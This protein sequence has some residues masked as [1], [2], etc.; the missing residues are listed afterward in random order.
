[1]SKDDIFANI[2]MMGMNNQDKNLVAPPPPVLEEKYFS[3]DGIDTEAIV[4]LTDK[5]STREELY[6]EVEKQKAYYKP[7]FEDY[8]PELKETRRKKDL[9][10][11]SWKV[12]TPEDAQDFIGLMQGKGE[13][14]KLNIP[15]FGEPRGVA[16]TYYRTTFD[17]TQE[18][19]ELGSIWVSFKGV[20][21]KAHVFMNGMFL[22][23]HEGFFAPFEFDFTA[24]AKVGENTLF[25]MVENDY[26]TM[27]NVSEYQGE[28]LTG[29]KLYAS[30][31]LGYDDPL[32][33]WHHCPPGMGIYQDVCIESRKDIFISDI[34][35]RPML[36][37]QKAEIWLELHS[38]Q[39]GHRDIKINLSMYGQNFKE[40][41]F[42][43]M[44]YKPETYLTVGTGDSL[45][46]ANMKAEGTLGSGIPM[47]MGRGVN[48]IKIPV[49]M[50]DIKKWELSQPW[51]YQL[52]VQIIDE[53]GQYGD[54]KQRHFGMRSFEMDDEDTPKGK[55]YF[56]GRQIRLRGAN[57]MGHEQQCVLKKDWEQLY[58]D[59]IL[60]KVCNMNFLRLTQ[61]PVQPEIYDF[62]DKIGLMIQTDL[63]LFAS[64]RRNQFVEAVRQ[65]QEME[66][67]IRSHPSTI[68]VSY[69]N[70][71][72]PNAQ[73]MPHRGLERAE[74]EDFFKCADLALKILNPD[75]VIKHV[76]GDYDP[77]TEGFPDNHCYPCWYN[78]HGIDIGKLHKGY[79]MAIKE[80]WHYGC[81]EYG[82]EGL[83][84]VSVMKKYY[85]TEWL[86]HTPK[87]EKNWSPQSILGA[88]TGNFHYF[89]YETQDTLES[90]VEES[91]KH[92]AQSTAL[93][94]QAFRRDSRMNSFAYHLF[95]DAFPAGWMK[96]IMDVDRNPKQAYF[97]YRDALTPVMVSLRTDRVKVFEKECINVEA[98]I[99][100][101]THKEFK[102]ATINY[103]VMK[104]G[105]VFV[106]QKQK[107]EMPVC[108]SK[109]QGY[110]PFVAPEVEERSVYEIHLS[111]VDKEE[112]IHQT[113]ISM[114]VFPAV[115]SLERKVCFIGKKTKNDKQLREDMALTE[116]ALDGIS[117]GDTIA[118]I[119]YT[120]YKKQEE[121]ILEKIKHGAKLMFFELAQGDYSIAEK[122][123][124]VKNCGMLPVHFAARNTNH[125]VVE[126][127]YPD[128]VKYWYDPEKDYI[129]PLL[130]ATFRAEGYVDIL[131]SGN[132]D[133][134][135]EWNKVSALAETNYGQGLIRICQIKLR[136]RTK[137]NPI[138]KELANRLF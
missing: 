85:P 63:P 121:Q 37:E 65:T 105:E 51:L 108:E 122:S 14:E 80:G 129:T 5:M 57:T 59:L 137:H 47:R 20:D 18:D 44:L 41:V 91:Q 126:G 12:G 107:V 86:P 19:L 103:Q 134:L 30:T 106:A 29:D 136:G 45:T 48:Y 102:D 74:L 68:M 87:E 84:E 15:H 120:V 8:A 61:R 23:S 124:V 53:Q 78:G 54:G 89:F 75:R 98:W 110:I 58:T 77:P 97:A 10:A 22:G 130:E 62:C 26:I 119:D 7:F 96:T 117:K 71:P 21:Y 35:V 116:V 34:F 79:W 38:C 32:E 93:M 135:G 6:E 112:V 17:L 11:F 13:W 1:M 127:L 114:E 109:F 56:N 101:D 94:T 33:G 9:V 133:S 123:V 132:Q 104:D 81:G 67:L 73:N 25:V 128:D 55:F 138:A 50:E 66:H 2:A 3:K 49:S 72:M 131:T 118:V 95:I 90:W 83:E 28:R 99:C 27:G 70:E 92:Q 39:V 43:D 24:Q 36:E 113:S 82:I 76:D 52:Q 115:K 4:T 88:Q 46:E 125:E 69:I 60:A 40:T 64:L 16:T 100:N 111:L 42:E 31:G